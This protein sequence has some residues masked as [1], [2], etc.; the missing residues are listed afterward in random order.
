ML[1]K[2]FVSHLRIAVVE[3]NMA[4]YQQLFNSISVTTA[5]DPYWKR[6]L[7]FFNNLEAAQRTILFEIIR[8][9]SVDTTSNIL[10]VIDGVNTLDG[11]KGEFHLAYEDEQQ[12]NGDLQS[13]FLAEEE[14][15]S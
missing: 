8:Q 10:G 1:A 12:L 4:I 13:L 2:E 7:S 9:V 6:A 11:L 3:E 14:R 15:V 5:S